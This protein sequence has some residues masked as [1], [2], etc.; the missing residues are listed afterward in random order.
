[1]TEKAEEVLYEKRR[2]MRTFLWMFHKN[3][4]KGQILVDRG[5]FL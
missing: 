1:M 2:K 4:K 3:A 5:G